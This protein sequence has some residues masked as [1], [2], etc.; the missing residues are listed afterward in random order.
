MDSLTQSGTNADWLPSHALDFTWHRH[1][2][3]AAAFSGRA[4]TANTAAVVVEAADTSMGLLTTAR[5]TAI[6]ST[7]SPCKLVLPAHFA[8]SNVEVWS[9]VPVSTTRSG[10]TRNGLISPSQPPGKR[11]KPWRWGPA[12]KAAG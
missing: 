2:S 9:N 7:T 6:T 12:G 11:P 8:L 5:K 4:N 10:A 3:V 1:A